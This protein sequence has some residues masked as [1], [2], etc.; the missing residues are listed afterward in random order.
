MKRIDQI[1]VIPFIDIMLVLLAIVLTTATF[2]NEE[3]LEIRLP[4][5]T[6]DMTPDATPSIEIAIDAK[7]ALFYNAEPLSLEALEARLDAL[8]PSMP[9][10]LRV[11]AAA[12]FEHFV[13][14]VDRHMLRHLDRL[15]TL[16]R[17]R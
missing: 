17:D 15:T 11:D 13:A 16:T 2:I 14:V 5:A 9:V 8:A 10:V 6:V 7:N 3:R 4:E 12:C 1:N